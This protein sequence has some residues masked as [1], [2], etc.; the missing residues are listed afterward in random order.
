MSWW[1]T[2]TGVRPPRAGGIGR[3]APTQARQFESGVPTVSVIICAY[4]LLR[5]MDI[6]AAVDSVLIQTVSA[7]ELLLVIDHNEELF[8]VAETAFAGTIVQV[9]RNQERQGLSGAR[10]T[11]VGAA[12]GDVVAFLDDDASAEV[13]WIERLSDHYKDPDVYGVGGYATPIWPSVRPAWLPSEFDW[14]VGCSYTGQPTD[15]RPVR[16]FLGCN[17]SLLRSVFTEIGGFSHEVG[18]IGKTPLGCEETELCIRL[19]QHH[20][21][22]RLMY[23]P[24]IRVDHRVTEERIR[25]RYFVRRCYNEGLSKAVVSRLVGSEQ[26]LGSERSYAMRTLPSGFFRGLGHAVTGTG[27]GSRGASLARASLIVLG[28]GVTVLGYTVGRVRIRFGSATKT[29]T[30]AATS[31]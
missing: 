1:S 14:V 24:A 10:N 31:N 26:A 21:Q 20:S 29:G 11:G 2:P 7:H 15:V 16:N 9:L 27:T 3:P 17:M 25:P 13:H 8:T 19:V 6:R 5:W 18:R 23:D 22:A 4:T 30:A 12:R 28:L